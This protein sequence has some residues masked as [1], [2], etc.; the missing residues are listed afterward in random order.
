MSG[1]L[2]GAGENPSANNQKRNP[3]YA[4]MMSAKEE[5]LLNEATI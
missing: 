1:G 4:S 5:Q 3:I 2:E